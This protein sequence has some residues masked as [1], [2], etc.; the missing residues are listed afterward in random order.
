MSGW[1]VFVPKAVFSS[2][3]SYETFLLFIFSRAIIYWQLLMLIFC[4]QV[5]HGGAGTTA[6]GLRAAVIAS[7]PF[8]GISVPYY[9][10]F[11]NS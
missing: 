7:L 1:A 2:A 4:L 11:L 5:H 8:A 10:F 3:C 9:C 6:A